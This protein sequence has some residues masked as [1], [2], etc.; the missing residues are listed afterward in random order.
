MKNPS[1]LVVTVGI[2]SLMALMLSGCGISK[3]EYEALEAELNG[4][5]EVYPPR[6]F[7]SLSELENWL[8]NNDISEEPITEYAD[9]WFRK[10]L[11]IQEDAFEDGYIISADY[12]LWEDGETASVW[13]TAIVRGRVFFWNPETDEVTEEMFFGTVK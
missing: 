11:R 8:S 9:D 13:C 6:D 3:A 1:R 7:D 12:D 2:L 10:A 4:I 5:K